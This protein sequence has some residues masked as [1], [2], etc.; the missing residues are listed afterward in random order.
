MDIQMAGGVVDELKIGSENRFLNNPLVDWARHANFPLNKKPMSYC[1][2]CMCEFAFC[3][4]RQW[5]D[6][7]CWFIHRQNSIPSSPSYR[8]ITGRN[9]LSPFSKSI[10]L[11]SVPD[12]NLET[13]VTWLPATFYAFVGYSFFSSIYIHYAIPFSSS[14]FVQQSNK[15]K[16]TQKKIL[17][18]V[19]MAG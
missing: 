8:H 16:E 15:M 19:K 18:E 5:I 3:F 4:P 12:R 2:F 14:C 1:I 7:C 13:T 9:H 6:W 11:S 10:V 17:K